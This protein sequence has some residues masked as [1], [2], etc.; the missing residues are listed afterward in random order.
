MGGVLGGSS[1]ER[2]VLLGASQHFSSGI[3]GD[4]IF[5]ITET[6]IDQHLLQTCSGYLKLRAV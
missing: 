2:Y 4:F 6:I 1:K 3:D 5:Y